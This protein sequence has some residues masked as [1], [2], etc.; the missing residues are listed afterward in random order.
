MKGNV[1]KKLKKLLADP[2]GRK[3]FDNFTRGPKKGEPVLVKLADGKEYILR[4]ATH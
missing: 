2:D 3:I 1:P 4:R